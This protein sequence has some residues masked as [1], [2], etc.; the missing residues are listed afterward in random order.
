VSGT[1]FLLGPG[2]QYTFGALL[3]WG[4][5]GGAVG[6]YLSL[7]LL[8]RGIRPPLLRRYDVEAPV[9]AAALAP[10]PNCGVAMAP[11]ARFCS[12]CGAGLEPPPPPG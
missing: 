9:A 1:G 5:V 2:L 12:A 11:E 4:V 6:G 7:L 3:L 8:V 10:C